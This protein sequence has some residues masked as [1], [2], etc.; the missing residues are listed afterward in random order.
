MLEANRERDSIVGSARCLNVFFELDRL[1]FRPLPHLV[2]SLG[3]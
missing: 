2:E 3:A 1:D